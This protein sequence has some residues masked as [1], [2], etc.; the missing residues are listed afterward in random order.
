MGYQLP[1]DDDDETTASFIKHIFHN[2]KQALVK[3]NIRSAFMQ[4][5]LS[6]DIET[7]PYLLLFDENMIR[8]SPGFLALWE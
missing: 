1:F 6:Y 5:G 3:G 2:P 4:F 7:T 8:E